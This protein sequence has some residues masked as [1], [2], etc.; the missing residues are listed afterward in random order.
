MVYYDFDELPGIQH[1][2]H[3]IQMVQ[4]MIKSGTDS[5]AILTIFSCVVY[6][7]FWRTAWMKYDKP[8]KTPKKIAYEYKHQ[9]GMSSN[10]QIRSVLLESQLVS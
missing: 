9:E 3:V 6:Y 4:I 5:D 10:Y 1:S 8:F 7:D 2:I